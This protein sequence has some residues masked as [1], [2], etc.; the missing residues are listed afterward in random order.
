MANDV[1]YTPEEVAEILRIS[2][3]TV[4]ELIKRGELMAYHV[5]R[6][7]RIESADI[8]S[9][10]RKSKGLAP[11]D[12]PATTPS[13]SFAPTQGF[14][15]NPS[16]DEGLV[17]CGQDILLDILTRYLERQF[18]QVH[19][20]RRY[21]GSIDGLMAL[22]RGHAN[23]VTAHLWDSDTNDYNLPYVRRLLPGHPTYIIN[24]V[25]RMEGF[26]VAKGNPKNVTTWSD[27]TKPK[28][29]FI[30]R[31]RGSGARV[32]LD[33]QLR[34]LGIRSRDIVGYGEEEMTHLAVASKVARG[35][36]DVG[37][38]IEKVAMQFVN[39]D[40]IPLHK[41]R[42]DLVIR[43]EDLE[44]THFQALMSI[45]KSPSFRN[46]VIGIGGYDISSMG[47]IMAEI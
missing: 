28:V 18:P 10:K 17:I 30:N 16:S 46:E 23:A 47:E 21:I 6:K 26:Y 5:G 8:E 40:F 24:L 2:K 7:V 19:F 34:I 37:L 4:Y 32:L 11:L 29:R 35:E 31:E 33:E 20:L 38:G 22:Y 43:Q 14:S 13:P 44:R 25:Y 39:L 3:F 41:E 15:H 12:S 1:S 27:L 42:Y 36:A 9:Y 45:L